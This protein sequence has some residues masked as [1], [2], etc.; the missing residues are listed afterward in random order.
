MILIL[1]LLSS[2]SPTLPKEILFPNF[3]SFPFF[4]SLSFFSSFPE[5]RLLP[6]PF[7]LKS[8]LFVLKIFFFSSSSFLLLLLSIL[9]PNKDILFVFLRKEF[10]FGW[11][12]K[13]LSF[14]EL[15]SLD[16][17]LLLLLSISENNPP[18]LRLG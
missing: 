7:T 9:L 17:L 2:P 6:V 5:N 10:S 18:L 14:F 1:I 13:R 16:E 12:P 11:K 4:L 3:K 8:W 15:L